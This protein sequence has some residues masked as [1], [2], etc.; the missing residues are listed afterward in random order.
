MENLQTS[1]VNPSK[2][3][4]VINQQVVERQIVKSQVIEKVGSERTY[5]GAFT[6]E[7]FKGDA[8]NWRN[9]EVLEMLDQLWKETALSRVA[10]V[11]ALKTHARIPFMKMCLDVVK[12]RNRMIEKLKRSLECR[13]SARMD[14]VAVRLLD[15][16]AKSGDSELLD[17]AALILG[18]S[19][20]LKYKVQHGM[21]L[22]K[23]ET[24]YLLKIINSAA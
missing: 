17:I 12:N 11:R 6:P 15:K 16:G 9:P 20:V 13:D 22:T 7:D 21:Q 4:P 14:N 18:T 5:T 23:S 2:E 19:G 8:S 10:F 24:E 1:I 3:L